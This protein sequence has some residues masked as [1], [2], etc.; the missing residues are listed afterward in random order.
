MPLFSFSILKKMKTALSLT[1]TLFS[2]QKAAE[3]AE[4]LNATDTE[5]FMYAVKVVTETSSAVEVFDAD[6]YSV[7]FL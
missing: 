3:I 5:Q 1:W 7:G 6:G 4:H 2:P